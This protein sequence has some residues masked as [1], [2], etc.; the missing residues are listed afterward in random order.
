[1]TLS[2][3]VGK[4]TNRRSEQSSNFYTDMTQVTW[5]PHS[6]FLP[7]HYPVIMVTIQD[8]WE[9]LPF[10][11]HCYAK[12]GQISDSLSSAK[13]PAFLPLPK[14]L[15]LGFFCN[16][17]HRRVLPY[18]IS[19]LKRDP[20]IDIFMSRNRRKSQKPGLTLTVSSRPCTTAKLV[21]QWNQQKE[22]N[23]AAAF[24]MITKIAFVE[25]CTDL[26]FGSPSCNQTTTFQR[27]LDFER[28]VA[29]QN[30]FWSF[31]TDVRPF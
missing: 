2:R 1:M 16:V 8:G 14:T 27:Q 3:K 19:I 28:F 15:L 4:L 22:N 11:F 17:V 25:T 21:L 29:F 24:R 6:L 31:S 5:C 26:N 10:A 9:L 23:F 13:S 18:L 30:K 7:T 20:F 12:A